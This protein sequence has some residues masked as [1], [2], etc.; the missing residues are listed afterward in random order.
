M[1]DVGV[2]GLGNM[3]TGIAECFVRSSVPLAVWDTNEAALK[4]FRVRV[5]V[6]SPGSMAEECVIMFFVV[7]QRPKL[8]RASRPTTVC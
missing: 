7:Q 2:V 8:R 6:I 1:R 4:P 3:G 5:R